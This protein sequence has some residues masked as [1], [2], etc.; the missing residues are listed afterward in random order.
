MDYW[1]ALPK[2]VPYTTVCEI[3]GGEARVTRVLI[4]HVRAAGPNFDLICGFDMTKA[5]DQHAFWAWRE[6]SKVLVAVM[7]SI[8]GPY[9]PMGQMNK[10]LLPETGK[11]SLETAMPLA[12][13]CGTVAWR[14]LQDD[15]DC[16]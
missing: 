11:R 5:Q 4:K 15:L 9:G 1:V 10:H 2:A 14:Q 6:R 3:E 8:Y 13:F 7:A 16:Q 12:M